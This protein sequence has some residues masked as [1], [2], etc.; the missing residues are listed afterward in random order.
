MNIGILTFYRAANFGAN[1]QALSTFYYLKNRGHNPL[2]IRYES[3]YTKLCLDKALEESRQTQEHIRFVDTYIPNQT[4]SCKNVSDVNRT[5]NEYNL[6]AIIIGSDAVLQHHPLI[7]RIH[8]GKRKPFYLGKVAPERMFPNVF[9]S[10]GLSANIPIAMMSVSSQNSGYKWFTK[11]LRH[12]MAESLR[13]VRYISVRDVWTKNML[14]FLMPEKGEVPVTPDPVFAFNYNATNII[15][16]EKDIR[17]RFNLP[18][19]YALVSLHSQNLKLQQLQELKQELASLSMDCVAFPMPK[20]INFSHPFAYTIDIPLN[21][22]DWYALIKYSSAY[23]GSNMHPIVVSLH[24]AVPCFSIDNWGST[25]FWGHKKRDGSSKVEHIM[26]VFKV[27]SNHAMIEK[28]KCAVSAAEIKN[29]IATFPKETVSA[30]AEAYLQEYLRM[31][32]DIMAAV[33]VE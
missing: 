2:F 6:E 30:K 17:N 3:E 25:D 22:L 29:A 33:E 10:E 7:T 18:E 20:G 9:W 1:L 12:R 31:M 21:P 8:K 11:S 26:N 32:D 24:N 14:S 28:G 23:I 15:P 19:K 5:I 16:T 27:N 13:K 4:K